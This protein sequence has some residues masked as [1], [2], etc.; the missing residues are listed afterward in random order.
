MGRSTHNGALV[1]QSHATTTNQYTFT[2]PQAPAST[3]GYV[4][5]ADGTTGATEWAAGGGAA[6]VTVGST[7]TGNAGTNASVTDGDSGDDVVL[8]FTIPRGDPGQQGPQGTQGPQGPSGTVGT[9]GTITSGKM[10]I[11][12][13][14]TVLRAGNFYVDN[15]NIGSVSSYPSM[16]VSYTHLTLPTSD[17]V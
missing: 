17:L 4:L 5:T 3:D 13:S 9:S 14:S 10:P 8:N 16:A 11:W 12:N 7:T 15:N 6:S 1:L 2:F